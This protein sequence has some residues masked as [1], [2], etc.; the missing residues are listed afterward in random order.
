MRT[1]WSL[2]QDAIAQERSS[3]AYLVEEQNGRVTW[4]EGDPRLH[5]VTDPSD[6]ALIES[7]L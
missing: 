6:L 1:I 4:V 7:W 3:A 5:K 2:W